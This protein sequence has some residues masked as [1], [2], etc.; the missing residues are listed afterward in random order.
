MMLAGAYDL[1]CQWFEA[2]PG[3]WSLPDLERCAARAI[4]PR[5]KG[6][7]LCPEHREEAQRKS[8]E[9]VVQEAARCPRCGARIEREVVT[10]QPLLRHGGYGA[11]RRTVSEWCSCGWRLVV[12]VSEERP[13]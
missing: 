13:A 11:A 12:D 2:P 4:E 3:G 7:F 6:M 8:A 10:A 9:L 5:C 1:R